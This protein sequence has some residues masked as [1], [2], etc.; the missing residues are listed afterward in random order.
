MKGTIID[1]MDLAAEKPELAE[2]LVELAARYDFEFTT[3]EEL[4]DED[5][6]N[7]TGGTSDLQLLALQQKIQSHNRQITLLSNVMKARHD[8][9]KSTLRNIRS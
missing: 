2:E 5:L 9:E 4:S 7:V 6:E 3:N 8:T 1:F